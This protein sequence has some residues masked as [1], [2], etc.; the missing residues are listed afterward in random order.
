MCFLDVQTEQLVCFGAESKV[1]VRGLASFGEETLKMILACMS[2][3]APA[4][5]KSEILIPLISMFGQSFGFVL[6]NSS[7]LPQPKIPELQ[8][9]THQITLFLQ[10]RLLLEHSA[11]ESPVDSD[12]DIYTLSN[13]MV[14]GRKQNPYE[15]IINQSGEES[16]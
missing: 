8:D 10:L 15:K 7:I 5:T 13:N 4:Y 1:S 2:S 6:F 14:S 9:E 3:K 11:C 12:S 16:Q